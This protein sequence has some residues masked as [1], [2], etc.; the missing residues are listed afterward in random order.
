VIA[1]STSHFQL[2]YMWL[3]F[4]L[5]NTPTTIKFGVPRVYITCTLYNTVYAI[6]TRNVIML[7]DLILPW[8]G[9]GEG[10][11]GLLTLG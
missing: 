8:V 2:S 7:T 6:V 5:D 9:G 4:E 10:D 1:V 11:L 3:K